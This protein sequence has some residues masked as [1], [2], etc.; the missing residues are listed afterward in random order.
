MIVIDYLVLF[1][2]E[3]VALFVDM[4]PYITLGIL[5]AGVLHVLLS[6]DFVAKQIGHNNVSSVFKSAI[7]G[8]PLPLCSC[9]V[10]PTAV[11]LKN[12]GASKSAVMSF[13]I[14]T[15]QTGVDSIAATWGMLGPLFAFFR[16]VTALITG[17][18]GGIANF[19][20]DRLSGKKDGEEAAHISEEELHEGHHHG[21]KIEMD[22]IEDKRY[23]GF[24][25]KFRKMFDYAFFELLDDIAVNFIVGLA[26]SAV[27]SIVIPDDFFAGSFLSRPLISMV[28]MVIIGIPMYICSTASI[29]IAVAMIAKGFSPGAAYVFLVAGPATNAA[30]LAII[31][32]A[33]GRKTSV[34]YII[35]IMISSLLFGFVMNFIYTKLSLSPFGGAETHFNNGHVEHGWFSI[36]VSIFF[37]I[38][39]IIVFFR[40]IRAR[41]AAKRSGSAEE[42]GHKEDS[43]TKIGIEGMN[44]GHCTAN[45]EK[46]LGLVEGIEKIDVSLE[47]KCAFIDGDFNIEDAENAIKNAGYVVTGSSKK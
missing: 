45:V 35:T 1:F 14:S 41:I 29:P 23:A 22:T 43:M 17:M 24:W 2:N 21:P 36:A 32:K 3:I 16:A 42:L 15:P 40:Q 33:L 20:L 39:L 38:M 19:M 31:T 34:R 13:L 27:I 46:A 18:L 30:S 25:G 28:F 8:V 26:I 9:G 7:F 6:K 5:I 47:G 10:V 12:S 44:C 37:L 11:Y 4:V